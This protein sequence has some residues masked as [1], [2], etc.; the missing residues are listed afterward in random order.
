MVGEVQGV[1]ATSAY[2]PQK[3]EIDTLGEAYKYYTIY[4]DTVNNGSNI[5]LAVSE[6]AFY[7][8]GE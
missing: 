8:E 4:F 1:S 7:T 5:S 2:I 3:V 6:L